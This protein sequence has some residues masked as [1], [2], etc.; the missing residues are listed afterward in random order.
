MTTRNSNEALVTAIIDE[1]VVRASD[2]WLTLA[3]FDW[4]VGRNASTRNVDLP[5]AKRIRFG[6]EILQRMLEKGLMV[7]GSVRDETGGFAAWACDPS[8]ALAKIS[9]EWRPDR[10]QP[11]MGDICWLANTSD[12]DA[13]AETVRDAVN[14][15]VG[16]AASENHQDGDLP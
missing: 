16:W 14:A 11:Q 15:R 1:V 3:E 10:A 13:Y 4:I 9:G 7:V 2:D 12:G 6:L 5:P 8:Q